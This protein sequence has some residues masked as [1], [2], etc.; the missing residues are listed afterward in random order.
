MTRKTLQTVPSADGTAPGDLPDVNVWLALLNTQHAHHQTARRYWEQTAAHRIGFCRVTMLG[1]LRLSTNRAVMGG[2]PY[3][4]DQAWR[5]YQA[6]IDLPE[7]FFL[8]EPLG[9]EATMRRHTS[10]QR[11][12]AADWTDVYLA[13]VA[14]R[15]GLRIVS[16]DKGFS[17]LQGIVLLAL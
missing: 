5:A 9:V 10:G 6:V 16:F 12:G 15:A 2:T 7:V 4:A 13:A 11:F 17:R 3:T 14:Q 8:Q 1:L